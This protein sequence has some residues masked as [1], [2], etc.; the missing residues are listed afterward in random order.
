MLRA[1]SFF[2]S[3]QFNFPSASGFGDTCISFPNEVTLTPDLI[4][5]IRNDIENDFPKRHPS[6]VILNIIPLAENS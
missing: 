5:R 6:V 3:Y 4:L 1:K 2:V